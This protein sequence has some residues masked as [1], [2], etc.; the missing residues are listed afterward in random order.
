MHVCERVSECK[1]ESRGGTRPNAKES[2]T[3]TYQDISRSN[4]AQ[5]QVFNGSLL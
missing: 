3:G 4:S 1:T 5:L 2:V